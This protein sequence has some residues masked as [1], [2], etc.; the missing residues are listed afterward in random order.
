MAKNSASVLSVPTGDDHPAERREV[1]A[2][3]RRRM[4]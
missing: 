4:P 3:A 2:P 1:A